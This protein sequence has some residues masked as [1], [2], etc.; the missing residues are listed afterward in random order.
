MSH[1]SPFFA[2]NV[3][4]R[5]GR[6]NETIL[7]REVRGRDDQPPKWFAPVENA[8]HMRICLDDEALYLQLDIDEEARYEDHPFDDVTALVEHVEQLGLF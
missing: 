5:Y 7:R 8:G 1:G 2:L 4:D 6:F 3:G